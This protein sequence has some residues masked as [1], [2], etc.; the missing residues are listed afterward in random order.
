MGACGPPGGGEKARTNS[1]LKI[2]RG[3]D[4][5]LVCWN[6]ATGSSGKKKGY[7][8]RETP[9]RQAASKPDKGPLRGEEH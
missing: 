5:R 9:R 7:T 4:M 3:V 1:A 2:R 6:W 8:V